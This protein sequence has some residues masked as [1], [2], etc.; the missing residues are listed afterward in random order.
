MKRSAAIVLTV[1]LGFIGALVA[2]NIPVPS[3]SYD[4]SQGEIL[5]KSLI[6]GIGYAIC[7]I[8]CLCMWKY[9]RNLSPKRKYKKLLFTMKE[10]IEDSSN[11]WSNP[12]IEKSEKIKMMYRC[13]KICSAK[14]NGFTIENPKFL[15]DTSLTVRF[16]SKF[17]S[18]VENDNIPEAYYDNYIQ[19]FN[20]FYDYLCKS[21]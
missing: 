1:I 20:A 8:P 14:L 7:F 4:L 18:F 11:E 9:T 6:H 3:P 10:Q 15:D 2:N 13:I 21:C 12:S 5:F 16:I 19:T 17:K